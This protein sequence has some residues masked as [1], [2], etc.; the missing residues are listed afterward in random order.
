MQRERIPTIIAAILLTLLIGVKNTVLAQ[1]CTKVYD[2][3]YGKMVYTYP[4]KWPQFTKRKDT[5]ITIYFLEHYSTTDTDGI[6]QFD[7]EIIIDETGKVRAPRIKGKSTQELTQSEK[8]AL[9]VFADMPKWWQAGKC[10]GHN[11]ATRYYVSLS[12][13]R[14]L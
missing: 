3:L 12:L 6:K 11:V 1:N 8:D 7:L 13:Y 14:E 2:P 9:K 4:Q 10:N 5:D